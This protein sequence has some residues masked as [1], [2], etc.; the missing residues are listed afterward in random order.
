[1]QEGILSLQGRLCIAY[2]KPQK[3]LMTYIIVCFMW[4]REWR[5]KWELGDCED[6]QIVEEA[7]HNCAKLSFRMDE[8]GGPERQMT[9]IYGESK[10]QKEIDN[11]KNTTT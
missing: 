11:N 8:Y 10:G 3:L 7:S 5:L 6:I 9:T 1:M 2:Y 4:T